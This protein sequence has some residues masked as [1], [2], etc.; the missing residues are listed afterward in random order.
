M[1]PLF[2]T[3]SMAEHA[4]A[5][6]AANAA[7]KAAVAKACDGL[8]N[9]QQLIPTLDESKGAA[10]YVKWRRALVQYILPAGQ[11]FIQALEFPGS[12]P[13]LAEYEDAQVTVDT[14]EGRVIATMPQMRQHAMLSCIRASLPPDGESIRL[15]SGCVHA[16]GIVQEDAINYDQAIKLLDKR[17]GHGSTEPEVD[18]G[19]ESKLLHTMPWPSEFSADAYNTYFNLAVARASKAGVNPLDDNAPSIK[20]RSGWWYVIAEPPAESF[21]FK[22]AQ[23][24]RAVTDQL[25]STLAHRDKW[26]VAM[27]RAIST[28]SKSGYGKATGGLGKGVAARFGGLSLAPEGTVL[29]PPGLVVGGMAAA[30]APP[31]FSGASAPRQKICARCPLGP[32]GQPVVHE[33]SFTCSVACLCDACHSDRHLKHACFIANGVPKNVKLQADMAAELTRL[34]GLFVLG[35][36][37]WRST[38]TTLTWITRMRARSAA[39]GGLTAALVAEYGAD[40]EDELQFVASLGLDV[41]QIAPPQIAPPTAPTISLVA[42]TAVAAVASSAPPPS[43]GVSDVYSSLLAFDGAVGANAV[44]TVGLSEKSW[45]TD[46]AGRCVSV[47]PCAQGCHCDPCLEEPAL[48]S[49]TPTTDIVAPTLVVEHGQMSGAFAPGVAPVAPFVE[50]AAPTPVVEHVPAMAAVHTLGLSS[51]RKVV[52]WG[53]LVLMVVVPTWSWVVRTN[54]SLVD[55]PVAAVASWSTR[56]YAALLVIWQMVV[57]LSGTY[58][59]SWP[60][61]IVAVGVVG[62]LANGSPVDAAASAVRSAVVL[63]RRIPPRIPWVLLAMLGACLHMVGSSV[64][65]SLS[66][67]APRGLL[68]SPL[69]SSLPRVVHVRYTA[70]CLVGASPLASPR[71]FLAMSAPLHTLVPQVGEAGG[72]ELE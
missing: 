35:Q 54:H 51:M 61:S 27:V 36:W 31:P 4:A 67:A 60:Q 56:V 32:D 46:Q 28:L 66:V 42:P 33:R 40:C 17:W 52:M 50:L 65:P 39:S 19:K 12:I 43:T 38:P 24:A 9:R 21:Y 20:L 69:A 23:E 48:Q 58:A 72:V 15:I 68:S 16:G 37:D 30:P 45:V 13:A 22:A 55:S 3:A 70:S 6:A 25:T 63:A 2:D 5:V 47:G 10:G 71:A 53:M 62:A 34:H 41:P 26:R 44:A 1:L 59:V 7:A 57:H 49:N 8:I 11:D 14:A 18:T 29:M 64:A